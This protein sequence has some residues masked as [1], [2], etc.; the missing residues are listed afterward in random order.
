MPLVDV[1]KNIWKT[2]IIEIDK[3]ISLVLESNNFTS[4]PKTAILI[5]HPYL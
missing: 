3:P 4:N 1:L 5:E 2:P